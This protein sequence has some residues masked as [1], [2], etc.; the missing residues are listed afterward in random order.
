MASNVMGR[1]AVRRQAHGVSAALGAGA[2]ILSRR[3]PDTIPTLSESDR[4]RTRPR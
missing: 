2:D 1:D 3:G 4:A